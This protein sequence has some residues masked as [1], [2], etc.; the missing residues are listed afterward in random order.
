MSKNGWDVI[1]EH[2]W[3][4]IFGADCPVKEGDCKRLWVSCG[5]IGNT[6]DTMEEEDEQQ[7]ESRPIRVLTIRN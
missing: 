1:G 3:G 4:L 5:E 6:K 7:V 2:Q